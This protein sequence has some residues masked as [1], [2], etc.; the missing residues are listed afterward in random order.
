MAP[1][2]STTPPAASGDAASAIDAS[3]GLASLDPKQV[4]AI[5]RVADQVANETLSMPPV[6]FLGR[7]QTAN[8]SDDAA[9]TSDSNETA[10]ETVE[11]AIGQA[12]QMNTGE[13]PPQNQST[14]ADEEHSESENPPRDQNATADEEAGD[15]EKQTASTDEEVRDSEM[16]QLYRMPS[17][18]EIVLE[19][20]KPPTHQETSPDEDAG[21]TSAA[22]EAGD[23]EQPP[24]HQKTGADEEAGSQNTSSVEEAHESEKPPQDQKTI[25]DEASESEKPPPGQKTISDEAFEGHIRGLVFSMGG[26]IK[27]DNGLAVFSPSYARGSHESLVSE[28]RAIAQNPQSWLTLE[29]PPALRSVDSEITP[30]N[31]PA[32]IGEVAELNERGYLSVLTVASVAQMD[33]FLRRIVDRE[34]LV[35]TDRVGLSAFANYYRGDCARLPLEAIIAELHMVAHASRECGGGWISDF[36]PGDQATTSPPSH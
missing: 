24:T 1:P 32:N 31:F 11:T 34:K 10:N 3:D 19:H 20:E 18:D 9:A 22:D 33:I 12:Q 25:A 28:L 35:L 17:A 21:G 16:T 36:L 23:S 27:D 26:S 8:S 15:S 14:S 2:A 4:D 5:I 7:A 13:E 29:D 30:L 6:S